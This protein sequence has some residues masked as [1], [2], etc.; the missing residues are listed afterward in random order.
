MR[1]HR[2]RPAKCQ[3]WKTAP[4]PENPCLQGQKTNRSPNAYRSPSQDSIP[5]KNWS[6]LISTYRKPM[7][8][9]PGNRQKPKTRTNPHLKTA[10]PTKT[11][12]YSHPPPENPCLQ[13][14]GTDRS[15]KRMQIPISR[16]HPQ[17]RLE[18]THIHHQ[19]TH[20]C[21]ARE[22]TEAQNGYK[23]TSQDSIPNKDWGL[24]TLRQRP[25]QAPDPSTPA[26][27][28]QASPS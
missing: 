4:P 23:S 20:A 12:A 6:L 28:T 26:H 16:Q 14:Q 13:G 9:G 8:A 19:K 11:G 22:Q 10:S 5:N 15:P 18:P 25:R 3:P 2:E 21:R 27:H 17:Q 7:P 24:L 1:E